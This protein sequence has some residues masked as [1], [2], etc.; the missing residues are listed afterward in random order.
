MRHSLSFEEAWNRPRRHRHPAV[1]IDLVPSV[2]LWR[3]EEREM[4]TGR[5]HRAALAKV[6]MVATR[7]AMTAAKA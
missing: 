3:G 2:R 5:A 4:L 7:A 1:V 6:W